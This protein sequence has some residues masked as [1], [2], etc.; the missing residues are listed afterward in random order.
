VF[1]G[2][3]QPNIPEGQIH[4]TD[5]EVPGIDTLGPDG[6][7]DSVCPDEGLAW[8]LLSGDPLWRRQICGGGVPGKRG[9]LADAGLPP[10]PG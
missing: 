3:P 9:R 1:T 7:L 4:W 6:A 10:V 5:M 2:A 8:T